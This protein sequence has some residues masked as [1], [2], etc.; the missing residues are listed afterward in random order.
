MA[1]AIV[2]SSAV[3]AFLLMERGGDMVERL[4]PTCAQ[5]T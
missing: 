1:D 4:L 3:L 5:R 2:D